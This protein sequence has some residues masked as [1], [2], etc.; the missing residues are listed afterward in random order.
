MIR[1][2]QQKI[3]PF[4]RG[5]RLFDWLLEKLEKLEI[6]E[7]LEKLEKLDDL[8]KR[9]KLERLERLDELENNIF[10]HMRLRMCDIFINFAGYFNNSPAKFKK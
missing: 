8:E 3:V 9:E 5:A 2:K 1:C 4:V 7:K 10:S 6:L